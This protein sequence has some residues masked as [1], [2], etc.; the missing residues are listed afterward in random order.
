MTFEEY[1]DSQPRLTSEK[2]HDDG[3]LNLAEGILGEYKRMADMA[4]ATLNPG[5]IEYMQN[6]FSSP[7]FNKLSMGNGDAV[8][9]NFNNRLAKKGYD[10]ASKTTSLLN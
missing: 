1:C 5:Y 7:Q 10:F 8:L 9:R 2:L 3:V 4:V 6:V